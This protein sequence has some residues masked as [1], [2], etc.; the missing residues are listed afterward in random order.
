MV[1]VFWAITPLQ[2]G[3][4]TTRTVN[5]TEALS[6]TTSTAYLSAAQQPT[7]LNAEYAYSVFGI[8]W[9]NETLPPYMNK[10]IAI[11]PFV[12]KQ[13]S[14]KAL[15]NETWTALTTLYGSDL[16]CW[17]AKQT[18]KATGMEYSSG[19]GCDVSNIQ[20]N[21]YLPD[22]SK[23]FTALYTG[24]WDNGLADFSLQGSCPPNAS[25]NFLALFSRTSTD[26]SE[27]G[28]ANN[29][30][31]LFCEPSY[32][33]QDVMATVSLPAKAI[34]STSARSERRGLPI[35]LFN[36]T[37]FE[38]TLSAGDSML[39]DRSDLPTSASPVQA[40]RL[41]PYSILYPVTNMIG[42]AIA[43]DPRPP[44]DYLDPDILHNALQAA[45]RLLFA[46]AMTAVLVEDYSNATES[47]GVRTRE[48]GAVVVIRTFSILVEVFLAI[49]VLLAGSILYISNRRANKL[50]SDPTT[51]AASMSLVAD[52]DSL[53]TEFADKDQATNSKLEHLLHD[54]S[55]VL[56]ESPDGFLHLQVGPGVAG[57]G[58]PSEDSS[59]NSS[60]RESPEDPVAA[61]FCPLELRKPVGM[62]FVGVLLSFLLLFSLL[63]TKSRSSNGLPSPSSTALGTGIILNFMPTVIATLM[64]PFWVVLNRLLCILK[65]YEE[66]QKP[67][68]ASTA[69]LNVSYSSLPPQLTVVEAFR[70]R[71]YLLTAVC[72]MAILA[73]LLAVALSAVFVISP[74]SI[75]QGTN[76]VQPW[77]AVFKNLSNNGTGFTESTYD[78]FYVERSNITKGTLLPKWT[79]ANAF[80]LPFYPDGGVLSP[81]E[82]RSTTTSL[83]VNASCIPLLKDTD[84]SININL[85]GIGDLEMNITVLNDQGQTVQC[86]PWKL[87]GSPSALR[88]SPNGKVALELSF[89]LDAAAGNSSSSADIDACREMVVNG[90]VRADIDLK[91]A[92]D[93]IDPLTD[94]PF[95]INSWDQTFIGCRPKIG[96]GS[97]RVTVDSQGNV[98][99]V[100]TI[101]ALRPAA[102]ESFASRPTDIQ[103][104]LAP[105]FRDVA[106]V[107]HNDSL[108][109][110]WIN[111]LLGVLDSSTEL[112]DPKMPIPT[113][114]Q[115][116]PRLEDLIQRLSAII[117]G[118]NTDALLST[119]STKRTVAGELLITTDR[120]F[121]STPM[122]WVIESILALSIMVAISLYFFRT[123][124]FLPRLPTT[125]A[126]AIPYFAASHALLDFRETSQMTSRERE[127]HIL[128]RRH[129]YLFG[130]YVGVDRKPHTGI[131]RAPFA[132][133][134][135]T[136]K[137]RA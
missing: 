118:T 50:R 109:S 30:T 38:T 86:V 6:M 74:T 110:N 52:S 44:G 132:V 90:W 70:S 107:W 97:A 49:L 80:Y 56:K 69:A 34:I 113:F 122:F 111:Y 48:M 57:P 75:S 84:N 15:G 65:P 14:K 78:Q 128:S 104:Q 21:P 67:S 46:R 102:Q 115:V 81:S 4:L 58:G 43:A 137:Q 32:F 27:Y 8:S 83:G 125:L 96:I 66:L 33:A 105:F 41:Q 101:D 120:I 22:K 37:N 119:P 55:C 45:H 47:I 36:I 126:A 82:F 106:G 59:G 53:L 116:S 91:G 112:V 100:Q 40:F 114:E 1:I 79:T 13:P 89:A 31:A 62:V 5:V 54:K 68:S 24:Y 61:P 133:P 121:L 130:E 10:E 117:L 29:A 92:T 63:E 51:I 2:S 23:N 19:E 12:L 42:Y 73:N 11:A 131:E 7:G 76:F 18:K 98:Q 26:P 103:G 95:V 60:S 9:L 25:H 93:L 99:Q 124:P 123:K 3:I 71:H 64:E 28:V 88:G 94:I 136:S 17:P 72:S 134:T 77:E 20:L 35:D 87:Q 135:T 39:T 129:T 16:R 85:T 108:P 127:R